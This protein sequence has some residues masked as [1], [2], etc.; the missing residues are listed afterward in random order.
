M[1]APNVRLDPPKV[2]NI[3]NEYRFSMEVIAVPPTVP[4]L[5]SSPTPAV[6]PDV[7]SA[8]EQLIGT[9]IG[10]R[11][12]AWDGSEDGPRDAPGTVVIKDRH[13]L[14]QILRAP[15]ELGL[16][17][18][19]I[20]GS[21]DIEGDIVDT[22]DRPEVIERFGHHEL[23]GIA[24]S[25]A[26]HL[27]LTLLRH[28]GVGKPG[29]IP[30]TEI[31]SA[32]HERLRRHSRERDARAIAHHYD[33]GNDF[34]RL[35]LGP[36]LVYSCGYWQHGRHGDL[37]SAQAD[38]LELICRKLALRPG[39]R[40]LDV[41]CGWGS[42][43]IHAAREH[44]VEV[45]GVTLSDEQRALALHRVADAGLDGQIEIRLQDYRD[46]ADGPFDAIASV[47]MSEHVGRD[48]LT[49][50]TSHLAELVRPGGRVLNHAIAAVRPLQR[51]RRRSPSFIERYIFPDGEILPLS[52]IVTA[53]EATDLE[54]RDTQSLREHY[55]LTLR[56][57][58]ANLRADWDR[59]VALV[60]E[61]RAR[62]WLLYL[63][64]CAIAFERGRVTI[65]QVLG[66]KAD[67]DGT[68]GFGW[69]REHWAPA[70]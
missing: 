58:V 19:F 17:R 40:M 38:K 1:I 3:E 15:N 2:F 50:Y 45:V 42:L 52:D 39:M 46:V 64:T 41:G 67:V 63:A 30:S 65:H 44:G 9:E 10:L 18:A 54:V 55:G 66:V 22:L 6:A 25:D 68:S 21:L 32:R 8:T 5:L 27:A 70:S 37:E 69:T 36:S 57:W 51:A 60:G 35:V 24:P 61:E 53:F 26:A 48:E 28:G 31:P 13:A 23:A 20:N 12:R 34:Y 16:A 11:L 14:R 49:G 43:A 7:L 33:V 47:G 29:P 59:A 4:Q 56:A 62:T